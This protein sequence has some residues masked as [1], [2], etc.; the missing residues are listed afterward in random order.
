MR[1]A[2]KVVGDIPNLAGSG[3][4][5]VS[6]ATSNVD[7]AVEL[8]NVL[9][10]FAEEL[11][12]PP[13]QKTFQTYAKRNPKT[14]KVYIDRTS[15]TR[16]PQENIARRDSSHQKNRE[17]YGPAQLDKS[18][19]NSDAIRGREQR[20]IEKHGGARSQGGTSGNPINSISPRN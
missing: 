1:K 17:G 16:S 9:R 11:P 2:G 5:A 15:G 13:N 6:V 18:S 8:A 14:G 7:E 4:V 19:T 20:T 3:H 10:K 12:V